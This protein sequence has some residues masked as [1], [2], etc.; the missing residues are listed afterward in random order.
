MDLVLFI[1]IAV[2]GDFNHNHLMAKKLSD[3]FGGSWTRQAGDALKEIESRMKRLDVFTDDFSP[4]GTGELAPGQNPDKVGDSQV[5][6]DDTTDVQVPS[7]FNRGIQKSLGGVGDAKDQEM[8]NE[9]DMEQHK[10]NCGIKP[11]SSQFPRASDKEEKFWRNE[12]GL[13]KEIERRMSLE[14]DKN[15]IYTVKHHGKEIH[16]KFEGKAKI[17]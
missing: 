5:P 14:F 15:K 2:Y 11:M 6:H 17:R 13:S 4:P 16:V 7:A 3:G 1:R 9:L 10:M 12:K 8:M